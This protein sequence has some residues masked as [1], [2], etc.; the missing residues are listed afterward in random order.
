MWG[1]SVLPRRPGHANQLGTSNI[2]AP[3]VTVSPFQGL[4][5]VGAGESQ[6]LAPLAINGRAFSPAKNP[7]ERALAR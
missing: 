1:R 6:G 4:A 3:H 7:F 2:E 5:I